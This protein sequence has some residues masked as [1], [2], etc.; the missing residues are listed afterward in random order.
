M[1]IPQ[2]RMQANAID[3]RLQ[4]PVKTWTSNFFHA[5]EPNAERMPYGMHGADKTFTQV[6][7][8]LYSQRE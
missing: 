6:V 1:T 8:F 5:R 7:Q 3:L 2:R 4:R